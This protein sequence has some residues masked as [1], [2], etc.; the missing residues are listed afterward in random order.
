M[1]YDGY[2]DHQSFQ[3]NP[4][5][6]L[7]L[8][9]L[10]SPHQIFTH[11]LIGVVL[12]LAALGV[13]ASYGIWWWGNRQETDDMVDWQIYRNDEYGFEFKYPPILRLSINQ[14]Q[15][16]GFNIDFSEDKPSDNRQAVSLYYG[17]KNKGVISS[18][19]EC[20]KLSKTISINSVAWT[21]GDYICGAGGADDYTRAAYTT[22]DFKTLLFLSLGDDKYENQILSTFKF[23]K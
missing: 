17:D 20:F 16:N 2:M 14:V 12:I 23:T 11:K 19:G 9:E 21:L 8:P 7:S 13:G 10:P 18:L 3:S 1:R 5:L 22:K 6:D 15:A 4:K